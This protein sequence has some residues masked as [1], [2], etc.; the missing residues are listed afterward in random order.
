MVGKVLRRSSPHLGHFEGGDALWAWTFDFLAL[1]ARTDPPQ[2]SSPYAKARFDC[3]SGERGRIGDLVIGQPRKY[4][5][6]TKPKAKLQSATNAKTPL[7]MV[8]PD[9]ER[10]VSAV[11]SVTSTP[12][13]SRSTASRASAHN[14]SVSL[15]ASARRRILAARLARASSFP[16]GSS[17]LTPQN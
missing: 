1:Q 4:Q 6:A 9:T 2:S 12:A 16:A 5:T 17:A 15:I 8:R 13:L 3:Q 10:S 11:A 7:V 14:L